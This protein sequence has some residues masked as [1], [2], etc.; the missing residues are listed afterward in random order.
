M[1][2]DNK[3]KSEGWSS[4][5]TFAFITASMEALCLE[6]IPYIANSNVNAIQM[7]DL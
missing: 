6:G 3:A 4:A 2:L 5:T 1:P 7:E